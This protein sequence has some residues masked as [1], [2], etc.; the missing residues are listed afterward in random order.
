MH[1][2]A[3]G[4]DYK[5]SLVDAIVAI[6]EANDGGFTEYALGMLCELIEDCQYFSLTDSV[7]RILALHGPRSTI[8]LICIRHIYSRFLLERRD[9]ER[10]AVV[11][12]LASFG[13]ECKEL[14]PVVVALLDRCRLDDDDDVRDRAMYYHCLLSQDDGALIKSYVLQK[15][16]VTFTVFL[17][18]SKKFTYAL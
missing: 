5:T 10:A 6:A 8:P 4:L 11:S 9:A 7:M 15:L 17:Q 14:R 18:K 16:Q 3:D 13:A 12:A 2:D 1:Q